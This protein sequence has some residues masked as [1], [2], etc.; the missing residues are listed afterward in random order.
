V[1]VTTGY[2]TQ[3]MAGTKPHPFYVIEL[4]GYSNYN[5]SLGKTCR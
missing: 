5:I 1:A 2:S 4:L 3:T